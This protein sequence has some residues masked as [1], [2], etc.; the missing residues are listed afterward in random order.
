MTIGN[1]EAIALAVEE[2]LGV[3][4]ISRI[5]VTHLVPDRV[6][7]LQIRG[8]ELTRDI[9]IGQ[10]TR[11]PATTAQSAFWDFVLSLEKPITNGQAVTPLMLP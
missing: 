7:T 2:G 6:A 8:V 3:G 4:F 1:S 5:V 11:R 9:Y 10:H